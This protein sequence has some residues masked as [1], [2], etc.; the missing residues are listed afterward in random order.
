MCDGPYI[1][2]QTLYMEAA[3]SST[4]CK[5]PI[6][7]RSTERWMFRY[8]RLQFQQA[9]EQGKMQNLPE[10]SESFK[11][12]IHALG[13]EVSLQS[14]RSHSSEM[15]IA[16]W[17]GDSGEPRV[18]QNIP[19]VQISVFMDNCKASPLYFLDLNQIACSFHTHNGSC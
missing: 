2:T 17:T 15:L 18:L 10:T 11:N 13:I 16:G 6:F 8:T 3:V 4:V 5:A 1:P 19:L 9:L 7:C 12:K 14:S